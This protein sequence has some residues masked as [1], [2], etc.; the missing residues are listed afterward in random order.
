MLIASIEQQQIAGHVAIRMLIDSLE[1]Q[2]IAG[3]VYWDLLD[4]Y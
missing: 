3:H 2:Q 1:Q 4:A